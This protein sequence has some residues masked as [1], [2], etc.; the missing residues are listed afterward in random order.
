MERPVLKRKIFINVTVLLDGLEN[1]VT[2]QWYLV[3][4]QQLGKTS[5]LQ[6]YVI[7]EVVR[8]LEILIAVIANKDTP[9]HIV[10]K[11]STSVNLLLV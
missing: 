1:L 8:I 5:K 3:K 7:T 10:K 4:M 2:L 9:D 6:N 11:K